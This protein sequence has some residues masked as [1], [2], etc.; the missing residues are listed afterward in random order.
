MGDNY[1]VGVDNTEWWWNAK[2]VLGLGWV[3]DS[4][5]MT[6]CP[7]LD[8]ELSPVGQVSWIGRCTSFNRYGRIKGARYLD[9]H[10]QIKGLETRSSINS[11]Q[12][13]YEYEH[14]VSPIN[15]LY[16]I[17]IRYCP[18]WVSIRWI[19]RKTYEL[20]YTVHHIN[21]SRPP[22]LSCSSYSLYQVYLAFT[23]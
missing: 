9:C 20:G 19:R 4:T 8:V 13:L 22:G 2:S 1:T 14:R 17:G 15:V 7:T 21:G 11:T 3:E 16:F 6:G 10:A 12:Y 18:K 5:R 23:C